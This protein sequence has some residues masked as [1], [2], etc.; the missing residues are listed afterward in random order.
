MIY[1][2]V[3]TIVVC[4]PSAQTQQPCPSG[5][6]AS[7]VQGYVLDVSQQSLFEASLAP[8]DY[9]VAAAIWGF[10]FTFVVGLYLVSKSAGTILS[11]IRNL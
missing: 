11:A 7:T 5:M 9:V 2:S 1:G 8:F 10:A 3:Q 4:I 6:A